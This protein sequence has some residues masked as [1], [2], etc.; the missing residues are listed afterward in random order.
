M[1]DGRVA[2]YGCEVFL[3]GGSEGIRV[4]E[5]YVGIGGLCEVNPTSGENSPETGG[6]GEI[7]DFRM[8]RPF[9]NDYVLSED[10]QLWRTRMKRQD[11]MR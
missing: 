8:T 11:Q 2:G 5:E 9:L 6:T 10:V 4:R 7:V 1:W 3:P